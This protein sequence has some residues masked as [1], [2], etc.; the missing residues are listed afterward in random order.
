MS[1]FNYSN[2]NSAKMNA[3]PPPSTLT[4]NTT[5]KKMNSVPPPG[6]LGSGARHNTIPPPSSGLSKQG[7]STMTAISQ[8]AL[9]SSWGTGA[10]KRAVT[11]DEYFDQ[12][13]EEQVPDLAYIPSPG[14]PTRLEMSKKKALE[15]DDEDDPLDA[16]MAGI[17]AQV[18]QESQQSCS[19]SQQHPKAVR[20]DLEEEDNEES[21]Y[22][23]MEENPNAGVLP[24]EED[25]I[26]IEYDEDGNPIPPDKKKIIDPLPPIDH[27]LI[28]YKPF[29]KNFY[30]EH[31]E[32]KL[33]SSTKA[34]ELRKKYDLHVSG[35]DIPKPVASF[36][37]FGFDDKLLKAITK[38]EYSSPTPIQAQGVP[39]AMMGRDVLG[40][41]QTGSGKTA[42]FLWPLLK[43]VSVQKPVEEGEGPIALILA[44]TRE[45][46]I[47]IYNEA[48]KFAR[49]YDLRVI[50]AYGGGSKWEQSLAL[51][52]GAEIVVATPGR[53][54]DHVKGGA[55]NLQ[56]VTFLVLDEADRMFE[57]GF[58]PQVRSVC[59]HVRPDRQ[60][61]L[62]SATFRKKI[63]RLAKDALKD[64]I[65]ISQGI[66]GQANED[67]TQ[68]TLLLPSQEAKRE[69]L[70]GKLVE[71]MSAGSVLIFVTKKLDAEKVAKD[72]L[73]KEYDCLL[74][75]GDMEQAERNKVITAFKKQEVP[76]LV[77][78]DVAARGLDIPHIRTV[79]NYDIAR[80]IDTHTHRIGR[81]GRA[82]MQ[83]TAYTLLTFKDKEFVGHIVKNLEAAN[84]EVPQDVLDLALQSSWFRKQR[85]KKKDQSPNVGGIGLGFKETSSSMKGFVVSSSSSSP[86][87]SKGPATDR[88][89]AMK[90]AFKAQYMSQFRA[91]TE[92]PV[93]PPPQPRRKK[94]RWE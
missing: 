84:Q 18:K 73:V 15:E 57:L 76:L 34:S 81:T 91:S 30:I 67:V 47:Q 11:E 37:H 22:R 16:F 17:E 60:T 3:V 83:G 90:D 7:Y 42:A 25:G 77:A 89:T 46:A 9:T 94:S 35:T 65:K 70:F 20:N 10:R 85:F 24:V 48:K 59:N 14:S 92:N 36:G 64:P 86:A 21:Y 23:Y 2:F 51:K 49:V 55:T 5:H 88:L 68:Q 75:H 54:I 27:A 43:H 82:G 80:D 93:P 41:A 12:D 29:Q 69:W 8:N 58:E 26:E 28:E 72:L 74:L 31:P 61:L 66:T 78:T 53:I 62:F 13:D 44:P 79:I 87:T 38:A 40:V 50:C 63:E 32:I 39:C 33:L 56:R 1:G 6:N 71:L 4:T 52:E 45:L 19:S